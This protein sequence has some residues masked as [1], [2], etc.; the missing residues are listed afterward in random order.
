MPLDYEFIPG[1][2]IDLEADN[3]HREKKDAEHDALREELKAKARRMELINPGDAAF[4]LSVEDAD[5]L[6]EELKD[7]PDE[8]ITI[9]VVQKAKDKLG[10]VQKTAEEGAAE[11]AAL[12]RR[13]VEAA[14]VKNEIPEQ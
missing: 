12:L 11:H 3:L 2:P 8:G 6:A 7:V 9:E 1:A 5:K 14:T 4:P 13:N 10:I